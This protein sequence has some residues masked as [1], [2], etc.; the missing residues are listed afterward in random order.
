MTSWNK[1]AETIFGYKEHEVI[2]KC[3]SILAPNDRKYE[4]E[5]F[6]KQIKSGRSVKNFETVR[7]RK[8]GANIPVS[9]TVS[10][11]IDEKGGLV[12]ASAIARDLSDRVKA[13]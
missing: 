8:D 9:L 5:G 3:I 10:P 11:I 13:E 7:Q 4:P 6:L 12:G 2:G 1:G